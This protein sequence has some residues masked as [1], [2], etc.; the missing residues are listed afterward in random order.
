[1]SASTGN[2]AN[3]GTA[4][5]PASRRT[6]RW[7]TTTRTTS[8]RTPTSCAPSGSPRSRASTRSR[9]PRPWPGESSTAT[10][11]VVW[12]DRLTAARALPGQGLPVEAVPGTPDQ[13]IAQHRLRHRP[14]RGGLDRQPDLVDHRQRLRL[15]GAQGAAPRGHA[16]PAALRQD[17]PGPAARDRHGARVPRQVRPPAARRHDQA[18]ARPVGQELRP[19]RLRGAARRP[20]LHQGRR[21]HQLAAVHAL[22]RPL[23][24]RDGGREPRARPRPA[25]SRATT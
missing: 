13:Y 25:R 22:A 6:P 15:Q 7:A 3:R 9:R 24:L 5:R 21:E 17:V 4:G 10:W 18:E 16:H 11:T 23:P 14:L 1:M 20:R 8:R 19:R 12:T 2:G